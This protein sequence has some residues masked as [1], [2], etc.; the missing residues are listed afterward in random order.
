MLPHL[1]GVECFFPDTVQFAFG[2][3]N[4]NELPAVAKSDH[5]INIKDHS[6]K[7]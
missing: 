6:T 4:N 1:F 2:V 5:F 7:D 3:I